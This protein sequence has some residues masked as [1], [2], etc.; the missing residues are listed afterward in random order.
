MAP[1]GGFLDSTAFGRASDAV[2]SGA[3]LADDRA[4]QRPTVTLRKQT[5][6]GRPTFMNGR[7]FAEF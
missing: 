2:A 7:E 6:A 1:I 4:L 3:Q 5:P